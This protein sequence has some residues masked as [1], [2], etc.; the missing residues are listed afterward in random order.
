MPQLTKPVISPGQGLLLL[1][2]HYKNNER[3]TEQLKKLYLS[4]A[5]D[6]SKK[7]KIKSLLNDK[8]LIG[9]KISYDAKVINDDPTRRYFETH[10]CYESL[11]NGLDKIS[12]A[13][14]TS[15]TEQLIKIERIN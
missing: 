14:L 9:Y 15:H 10:L 12:I 11:K 5:T 6:A 3:K 8:I 13:E 2:N 4:G 1:M 7:Q